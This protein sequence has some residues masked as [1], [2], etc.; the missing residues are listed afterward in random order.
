MWQRHHGVSHPLVFRREDDFTGLAAPAAG[1]RINRA[2]N[3]LCS[4]QILSSLGKEL[5]SQKLPQARDVCRKG[6]QNSSSPKDEGSSRFLAS[7]QAKGK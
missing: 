6:E 3:R 7:S 4:I 2:L 5:P 1:Q